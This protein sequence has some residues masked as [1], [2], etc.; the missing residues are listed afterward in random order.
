MKKSL[1]IIS[2]FLLGFCI[3]SSYAV[4]VTLLGP[5]T[6][7]RTKGK[8][9]VYTDTFPGRV[10]EGTLVI[11]NNR[12]SS[13]IIKING[14]QVMGTKDFNQ[15]VYDFE[16]P[17][18]LLDSNTISVELRSKPNSYLSIEI[19]QEIEAE[20][21][22]VIG[23][24]GGIVEVT[25]SQ[26]PLFGVA[27]TA[28]EGA[29]PDGTII[30]I[31]MDNSPPT[32]PVPEGLETEGS[33]I[34]FEA[35]VNSFNG[36]VFITI[37][38]NGERQEDEARFVCNYDD[39]L[40]EWNLVVPF[41]TTDSS[42]FVARV[43]HFSTYVKAKATRSFSQMLT[44]FRL[45]HDTHRYR[46][47]GSIFCQY[48]PN[49]SGICAGLAVLAAE[50]FN[51]WADQEGESLRCR[52]DLVTNANACCDAHGRWLGEWLGGRASTTEEKFYWILNFL[53]KMFNWPAS[54]IDHSYVIDYVWRNA[55]HNR[56]TPLTCIGLS[57]SH[58]VVATGWE[59]TSPFTGNIKIYDINYNDEPN[60]RNVFYYGVDSG[61][62]FL[63]RDYLVFL[64]TDPA[65]LSIDR[66]V[67][68]FPSQHLCIGET[69]EFMSKWGSKGGG[70]SQFDGPHGVAAFSSSYVYVT[71][72]NNHRVQMFT[73]DGTFL[74]K[75]GSFGQRDGQFHYPIGIAVDNNGY[76]YVTDFYNHR[77]Q[78]FTPF[79]NFVAK[80]GS[81]GFENGQF[82]YP[83]D[84]AV[85]S[86]G[87][88]Y[89]A[90]R[91]NG[92]IQKLKSDGT[93]ITKWGT[94]GTGDGQFSQAVSIAVDRF[95]FVYV[96]DRGNRRIQKFTSD[97]TFI[98]KWGSPGSGDGQFGW[99]N[100]VAVDNLGNVYIADT[101]NHRVQKFTP[102]GIF[103]TKWGSFGQ[104]DGQFFETM[105]I[106]VNTSGYVYVADY[107]NSRIQKF[108]PILFSK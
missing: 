88:V 12:V 18:G 33:Y 103:L 57:G 6:Y 40:E 36:L 58:A 90:D 37:P 83:S 73:S 59:M 63:Y 44:G 93:F 96:V 21:G 8:P 84:V 39:L 72:H 102:D 41:P 61:I 24:D 42:K 54:F 70:N 106:E 99:F 30:T 5:K 2:L 32:E 27:V 26:S 87:N 66:S 69:Y 94:F 35:T 56:V 22:A 60:F 20:A 68:D 105:A 1:I 71:D 101:E 85:D 77:I 49:A 29:L 38:F 62:Q 13:A 86:S 67:T 50:Y 97:G 52:W 17:I 48:D 81:L 11:K 74:T 47:D 55:L 14:V 43:E 34:S 78:K 65:G 25:S 80:W 16:I 53:I 3:S 31:N 64:I 46:N 89:I 45:E 9:N 82:S 104:G 19:E 95:G 107:D 76:V 7:L 4:E 23:Y 75:W 108:R 100:G 10:G 51:N 92:R 91:G 98:T 28:F 15:K 79:G